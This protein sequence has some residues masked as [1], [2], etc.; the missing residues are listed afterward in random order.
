MTHAAREQ[1]LLVATPFGYP[2][3]VADDGTGYSDKREDATIYDERDS[4]ATKT[5]YFRAAT[6]FDFQPIPA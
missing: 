3:Y 5:R 6:G 2:M 1:W 4:K